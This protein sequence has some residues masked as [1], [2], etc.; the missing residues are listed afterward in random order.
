LLKTFD[1]RP[2]IRL[3]YDQGSLEIMTISFKHERYGDFLGRLAVTLTE[4][5]A[6]PVLA[7]G[8]TTYRRYAKRRGLEP[9]NSYWIASEPK[10]RGK[11]K[12]DLRVDPPPDLAIEIDITRSSMRRMRIYASLGVPEV[13]RFDGRS[14]YFHLLQSDERYKVSNVSGIFP[15]LRSNDLVRFLEK[16]KRDEE[17]AVIRQFRN[18]I[19][20]RIAAGWR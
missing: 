3:T 5:L 7:G 11:F 8:S 18:W 12:I 15:G 20:S 1:E 6:L 4:E 10:V 19:Q 17:N 16:C 9:D 13:W 2:A 14:L